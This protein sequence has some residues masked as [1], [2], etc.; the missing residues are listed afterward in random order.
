[1]LEEAKIEKVSNGILKE[2]GWLVEKVR[3]LNAGYM[4]RIYIHL[5]GV[6]VWME[7]KRPGKGLDPLQEIRRRDLEER[8]QFV[9]WADNSDDAVYFCRAALVASGVP[10]GRYQNATPTRCSS[11]IPGPWPWKDLIGPSGPED[12]QSSY[13]NQ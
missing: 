5:S 4:D 9:A 10:S 8:H 13:V 6:V 12:P 1:M 7:F 11:F 2:E 3:F